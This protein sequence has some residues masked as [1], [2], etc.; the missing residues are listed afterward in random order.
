MT[1]QEGTDIFITMFGKGLLL[2][3]RKL[4]GAWLLKGP[5]PEGPV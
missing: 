2:I 5:W 4:H 1:I 3:V